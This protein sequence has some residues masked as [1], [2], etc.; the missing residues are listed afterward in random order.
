MR[1]EICSPR[2]LFSSFGR[3]VL[4]RSQPGGKADYLSTSVDGGDHGVAT[5]DQFFIKADFVFVPDSR[6][7]GSGNTCRKPEKII[8]FRWQE[9]AAADFG[10]DEQDPLGFEVPI[11]ET[12]GPQ[13]FNSANFKPIN[14]CCVVGVALR[15]GFLVA[16]TDFYFVLKQGKPCLFPFSD[17]RFF[18]FVHGN[19]FN[20][21]DC[22]AKKC[23]LHLQ[24]RES[25]NSRDCQTNT[26]ATQIMSLGDESGSSIDFATMRGRDYPSI[27][28][29]TVFLENRVGQLMQLIRRFEG[30]RTRIV[31]VNI[32][33]NNECSIVRFVLSHPEQG[34]EILERAGLAMVESDLIAVRLPNSGQPLLSV[35]VALLQAEINLIQAYPLLS[36]SDGHAAVALM[37]DDIEAAQQTLAVKGFHI[38][39]EQELMQIH[40]ELDGGLGS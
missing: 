10:Y 33:D 26:E 23:P 18:L 29:F 37:V 20:C 17:F 25:G 24:E 4:I 19:R 35:C 40:D 11:V 1:S 22:P 16:N 39:T 15:V 21:L 14:V 27:R 32:Q 5:C 28:Q 38:I 2:A 30:S 3:I 13:H 31:A 8:V 12:S 9:I 7:F 36:R 34:R 6:S